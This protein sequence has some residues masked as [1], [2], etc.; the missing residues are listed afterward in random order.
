MAM[1]HHP[2]IEDVPIKSSIYG[3]FAIATSTYVWLPE[4]KDFKGNIAETL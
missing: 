2:F 1:E 4:G 3:E